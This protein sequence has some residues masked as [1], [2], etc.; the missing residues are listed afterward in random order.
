MSGFVNAHGKRCVCLSPVVRVVAEFVRLA[1]RV[2]DNDLV[3]I[4]I[5]VVVEDAASI[6]T[7]VTIAEYSTKTPVRRFVF[8]RMN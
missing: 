1:C 8:A 4:I 7:S 6:R 2:V 3:I 5:V